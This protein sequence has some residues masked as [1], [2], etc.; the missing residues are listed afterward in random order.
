MKLNAAHVQK[1]NDCLCEHVIDRSSLEIRLNLKLVY[2]PVW[3]VVRIMFMH[4]RDG[5]SQADWP[6]QN[7]TH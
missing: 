4:E 1:K 6:I 5:A 3:C 7:K 2:V